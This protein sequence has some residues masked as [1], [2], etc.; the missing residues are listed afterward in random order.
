M[1]KKFILFIFIPFLICLA[2]VLS[3]NRNKNSA[4]GI[5]PQTHSVQIP[6]LEKQGTA[7]RLV[8][9]GKPFLLIAGELHNSTGGGFKSLRP[10]WKRLADKNLNS[11]IASVSWELVEPEEGNYDFS[12][13]DSTIAG[14]R[15]AG[16]KLVLIWFG[17]WKNSSSVYIPSWVKKDF[18]KFPRVHDESGKPLEILSTFG[19]A[20]VESDARAFSTLMHH[21]KEVDSLDQTVVM[22]QVEN[23]VGIND[24]LGTDPG[25]ARRDFSAQAN[26]AYHGSVPQELIEYLLAHRETLFPELRKVWTENGSKTSGSWEE[27]FGKSK[28]KPGREDW[29]YYSYYTEELFMAWNY[30]RYIGKI[31]DAGKNEYP[32]PMFVNAWLKQPD[33]YWPGRYPSGG[34]LPQVLDI[35]RAAAPSIDFISPDIYTDEFIW[36]CKEFTRNNNPLFIPETRGG[37]PAAARAFYVFGE[38]SA[39][40]FAPFGID[41][42]GYAINDPLD[43]T[44]AVLRQME[45]II[46]EN[47]GKGNMRGILVDIK[48][49]VQSFE[50]GDYTIEARLAGGEEQAIAGGMII[51][52]GNQEFICAGRSIDVFFI[53]RDDSMRVAVDAVDEGIFEKGKWVP[54]RRLN[55][56]EVHASTWDGTGLILP[57]NKVTIQKITLYRYK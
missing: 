47:Q 39:G 24:H 46:L 7:T 18:T 26:E 13:V 49:P 25:N 3:C 56:D 23:E 6:H 11:V 40:C 51:Q 22:M 17:S 30:A 55:G 19:N 14:A 8:V 50:M 43:E 53:P 20:S 10:V 21:I 44:Y 36:V 33:S 54:E 35:W 32:L 34:P 29:Q 31:A 48:T 1:K 15:E 4:S 52:T 16:L 38:Y 41:N 45:P 2:A 28:F 12:L 37:K 5:V 57:G 42:P 27:V 9:E